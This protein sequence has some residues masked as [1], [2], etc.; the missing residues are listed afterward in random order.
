MNSKQKKVYQ[1]IFKNPIQSY[2]AWKDIEEFL[3]SLGAK[4]SEGNGS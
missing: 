3:E 1:R 2:I 4:I